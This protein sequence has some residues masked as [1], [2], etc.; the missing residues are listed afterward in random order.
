MNV[1]LKRR[2]VDYYLSDSGA[3]HL[4]VWADFAGE[5]PDDAIVVKPGEFEASLAGG[6]AVDGLVER[7]DYDTAVILYTSGTTGSPKGAE[8]THANLG[9]NAEPPQTSSR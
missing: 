2:E 8:L 6:E 4:F 5:A 3:E 1:L 7:E 9:K